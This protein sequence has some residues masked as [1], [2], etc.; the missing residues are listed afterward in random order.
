M[1]ALACL[2]ILLAAA[3]WRSRVALRAA[4]ARVDV[5]RSQL[6]TE[7][8]RATAAEQRLDDARA[9]VLRVAETYAGPVRAM[10][11]PTSPGGDA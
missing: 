10:P 11:R 7:R 2:V 8:A 3:L 6:A 4:H 5:L 9:R 1:T